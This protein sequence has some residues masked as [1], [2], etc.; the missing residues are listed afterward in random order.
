MAS[1]YR[2]DKSSP[3]MSDRDF[4]REVDEAVRQDRYKQLLDKYGIYAA[5]AAVMVV[6]VVAGYKGWTY[7][8]ETNSQEA[9]TEFSQ[10]LTQQDGGNAAKAQE[11]FADLSDKGPAG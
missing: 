4:F 5:V 6:A 1:S 10:A 2:H 8:Q 7:W 9:G 11:A 3:P